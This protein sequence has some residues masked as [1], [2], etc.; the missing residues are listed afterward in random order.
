MTIR[1]ICEVRNLLDELTQKFGENY[2]LTIY[3]DGSGHLKCEIAKDKA[4][5]F[6]GLGELSEIINDNS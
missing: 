4:I 1:T 6:D 3:S 2:I 5:F